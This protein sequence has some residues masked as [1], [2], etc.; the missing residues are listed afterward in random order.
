[1]SPETSLLYLAGSLGAVIGVGKL[2]ITGVPLRV[3]LVIGHAV[4]SGGI[5]LAGLSILAVI[6]GMS[7]QASVGIASAMAVSGT[8]LLEKLVNRILNISPSPDSK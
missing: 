7:F 3:P 5:S 1:M 6:P 8:V 2:L 4:V